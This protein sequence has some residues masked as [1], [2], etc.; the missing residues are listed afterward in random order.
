M[1]RIDKYD[2]P[3]IYEGR[4]VSYSK[5]LVDKYFA[6]LADEINLGS[7]RGPFTENPAAIGCAVQAIV[8][9]G[10]SKLHKVTRATRELVNLVHCILVTTIDG[11][12]I[13]LQPWVIIDDRKV[14]FLPH[15]SSV[16]V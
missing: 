6:E 10:V 5:A 15:N 11:L 9:V 16:I 7:I 3:K 12:A 1:R 14:L 2:I 4:N 8:V 13:G